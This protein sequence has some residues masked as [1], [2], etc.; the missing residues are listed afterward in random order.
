MNQSRMYEA[1]KR[2][3]VVAMLIDIA[4]L[5]LEEEHRVAG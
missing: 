5:N 3:D 2:L 4:A 1:I